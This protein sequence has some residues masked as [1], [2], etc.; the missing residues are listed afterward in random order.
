MEIKKTESRS[1]GMKCDELKHFEGG[2]AT[3]AQVY[4]K[5]EVDEA[6]GATKEKR[7]WVHESTD[8]T[9]NFLRRSVP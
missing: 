4:K 1:S 8:Q 9:K 5:S 2:A 7:R 3:W 6:M